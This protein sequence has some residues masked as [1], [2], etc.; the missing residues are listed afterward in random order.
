MPSD[1]NVNQAHLYPVEPQS[2][3]FKQ[4]FSCDQPHLYCETNQP[5]DASS[6]IVAVNMFQSSTP[7]NRSDARDSHLYL[8]F[9]QNISPP[10]H[11]GGAISVRDG[12]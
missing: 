3:S 11:Y 8:L 10:P 1:S 2:Y 9:N 4:R 7:Q 12:L 5:T 6:T